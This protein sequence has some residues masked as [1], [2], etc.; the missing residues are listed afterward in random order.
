MHTIQMKKY[1]RALFLASMILPIVKINAQQEPHFTHNMFNN[2]FYN[3]GFTGSV[4][5]ICATGLARQQWVG[6]EDADGN[7][8][9][10]NTYTVSIHSPLDFLHGGIGLNVTSDK[11]GFQSEI[12]AK[13]M[14]AYRMDLGMGNLGIG[15]QLDFFNGTRDFAKLLDG[16]ANKEDGLLQGGNQSDMILDFGFGLQYHVP[17]KFYFGLSSNRILESESVNLY[18]KYKRHYFLTGGYEWQFPNNP[19][20]ILEPSLLVKSDAVKTDYDLAVLLKYNNKV[21]GGV[22]YSSFGVMD[23]IAVLLGLQIK[24]IRIGYAYTIPTSAIGSGGSHEVM[25]GYCFKIDFEKGRRSY[26][27]TRFL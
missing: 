5:G 24:D 12:M 15:I 7:N 23:P 13:L 21:W 3:P 2:I 4:A 25:V 11:L 1:I 20:F 19:S 26:R 16:A 27:N 14:Y 17:E 6:F 18:Y 9:A 22:S 8:V 10:P